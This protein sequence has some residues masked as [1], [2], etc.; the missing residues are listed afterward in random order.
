M[1]R[2]WFSRGNSVR[3]DVV[4]SA[5][6]RLKS[7][8]QGRAACDK[9]RWMASSYVR[10]CD[11]VRSP[12]AFNARIHTYISSR[13]VRIAR[14]RDYVTCGIFRGVIRARMFR[15][16]QRLQTYE[17]TRRNCILRDSFYLVTIFSPWQKI[18][19]R[20]CFV[21]GKKSATVFIELSGST[22]LPFL[23]R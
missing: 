20:V 21:A 3:G 10:F 16:M 4:L 5:I 19:T 15:K 6:Q 13:C 2:C 22:I 1:Y 8:S 18:D 11:E 12:I 7:S 14:G 17:R 9:T 23:S